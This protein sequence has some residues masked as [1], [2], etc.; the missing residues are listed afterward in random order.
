MWEKLRIF[1]SNLNVLNMPISCVEKKVHDKQFPTL[2]TNF[3]LA[4]YPLQCSLFCFCRGFSIKLHYIDTQFSMWS[5][6]Q[7][8]T[9]ERK[10]GETK[11]KLTSAL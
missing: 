1:C 7:H 9:W 3:L 2:Y 8:I 6:S 4:F 5:L 10:V 11:T